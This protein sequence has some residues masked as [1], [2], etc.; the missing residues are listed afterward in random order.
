MSVD[1]PRMNPPSL[2]QTIEAGFS[3]DLETIQTAL[4]SV[5]DEVRAAALSA[6]LR[7]GKLAPNVLTSYL[8]DP[9][10]VVRRRATELAARVQ[11]TSDLVRAIRDRL[12]DEDE[13]AETAAFVLGEA[14]EKDRALIDADTI[15]ALKN[16]ALTHPDAFCREAA[17][18]SLGA[19]HTGLET[20]LVALTDK[21][22][23]RRRAVIA[24]A[25]FEGAEVTAALTAALDDRDWQVRQAAE[26]L[27]ATDEND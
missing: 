8:T 9:S 25:P 20:I 5:D 11:P 27:L 4:T 1:H 26:D 12:S 16:Q 24:L 6:S 18:A 22:T 15:S 17:V 3:G 10:S 21:A 7:V 23:V 13:I 2:V 19:L 14:G